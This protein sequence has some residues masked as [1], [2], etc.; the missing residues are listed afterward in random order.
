MSDLVGNAEDRSS[1]FATQ[2]IAYGII[3]RALTPIN[4]GQGNS[5]FMTLVKVLCFDSVTNVHSD[6]GKLLQQYWQPKHGFGMIS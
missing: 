2:I 6:I 3:D 1:R 5:Y 4:K